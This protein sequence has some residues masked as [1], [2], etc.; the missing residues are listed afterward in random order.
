MFCIVS[1]WMRGREREGEADLVGEAT[2][3]ADGFR[4]RDEWYRVDKE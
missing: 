3:D 2:R 1:W 4:V